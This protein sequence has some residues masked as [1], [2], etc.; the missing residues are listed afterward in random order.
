MESCKADLVLRNC[1]ALTLDARRQR[2]R[3][4]YMGDGRILKVGSRDIERRLASPSAQVVD[5]KGRTV[6][7]AFHD[8]HC[9]IVA[10]AESLLNINLGPDCVKSI[11]DIVQKIRQ[12]AASTPP[13]QWIRCAGY[14]EFYLAEK[15][16]PTR[17]D[18]DRATT[19]HPVKLTHRSGH[20]HVLN[21]P[22]MSLAGI[23]SESEEPPGCMI[24]RDLGTGLPN[25]LLYGMG[26]YLSSAI[27]PISSDEL[28]TVVKRAGQTLL[29]L[30]VTAVQDA[31]PGN[32]LARWK[33]FLDWKRRGIFL[34]R[35]ILMFGIEEA[36]GLP[37][38]DQE[39]G[40]VSGAVKIML[41]EV[42]GCL[43]PSQ[44]ELNR[45]VSDIHRR[46]LQIAIHA[47]EETTVKAAANALGYAL[48]ELPDKTRRHR[49]EHCSICNLSTT[50][51]L[52]RLGATIVTNPAFIFYSG[53][54]YLSTVPSQQLRQLYALNTMLRAGLKPAA[55]SDAPVSPPDPL[56]GIYAAVTRRAETGQLV[57]KSEAISMMDAL[58][59]YTTGA[60]WSCFREKEAG[61]ISKGK[62]ADL[63]VLNADP[64]QVD[65]E[66]LKDINVEMTVLAG[67]VV[68]GGVS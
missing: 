3:T 29:Q 50:R 57:L 63:A 12:A 28:D 21:T 19:D 4:V 17:H 9:H 45:L 25:G 11:E 1:N 33:Q 53:E 64:F 34:P 20:A 59:L 14:N 47:V 46:G 38:Y 10:Y 18:L 26:A 36:P 56:K 62:Y 67:K 24:E 43:N 68:Y 35:T 54:R 27:P 51:Q 37:L 42:R 22:A 30:G 6:I 2:G 40:L 5:C 8:A 32:G 13:G 61:S 7:P 16:H 60:V 48:R 15:R 65:I 66:E 58:R 49:I 39:T 44:D 55:G 23:Y 52:H 41:D 31:S